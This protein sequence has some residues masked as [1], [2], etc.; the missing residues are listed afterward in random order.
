M[1]VGRASLGWLSWDGSSLPLMSSAWLSSD[2]WGLGWMFRPLSRVW[3]SSGG[4]DKASHVGQRIPG[5]QEWTLR[6]VLELRLRTALV[7]M[8]PSGGYSRSQE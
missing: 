2:D 5:G 7:A 1:S 3:S 6:S 8:P 4:L